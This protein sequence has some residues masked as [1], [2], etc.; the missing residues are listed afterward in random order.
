MWQRRVHRGTGCDWDGTPV[1]TN[2]GASTHDDRGPAHHRGGK[3]H[4]CWARRLCDDE[5]VHDSDDVGAS[6]HDQCTGHHDVGG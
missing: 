1:A 2:D 3:H 5:F 6:D 4:D